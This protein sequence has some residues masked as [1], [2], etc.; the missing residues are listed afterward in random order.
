MFL[1]DNKIIVHIKQKHR[2]AYLKYFNSLQD[3]IENPDYVGINKKD[4][5]IELVKEFYIDKEFVKVAIRLSKSNIYFAR[6]MY[7]LNDKRV[8]NFINKGFMKKV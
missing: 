6:T 5:S 3:I 1:L 8:Q 2:Q 7:I 4:Y